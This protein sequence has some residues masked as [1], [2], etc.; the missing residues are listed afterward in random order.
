MK[1][2]DHE[3]G[4][5]IFLGQKPSKTYW[6]RV[7]KK[8]NHTSFA[9]VDLLVTPTT[10]KYLPIGA[11]ILEGGCGDGKYVRLLSSAGYICFGLDFSATTIARLKKLFPHLGFTVSDVRNLKFPKNSFDGYWSLGVIEHFYKGYTSVL[12]EMKRVLKDGGILFLTFP[13]M[14]PLRKLKARLGLYSL[15]VHPQAEPRNFYQFALNPDRVITDFERQGFQLIKHQ[16]FDGFHGLREEVRA[17]EFLLGPLSKLSKSRLPFAIIRF[18][19][20]LFVQ[21]FTSHSVL[22]IFRKK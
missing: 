18:V 20:S 7:W 9:N 3:N 5:L 11:K 1:Y 22:L 17:M 8:F 13:Y 2:Y 10:K 12:L 6:D 14:S 21:N 15:F 19:I 16:P 4:R